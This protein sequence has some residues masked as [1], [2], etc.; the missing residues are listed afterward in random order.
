MSDTVTTASGLKR[1]EAAVDELHVMLIAIT[2]LDPTA[3]AVY[4][5]LQDA[6]KANSSCLLPYRFFSLDLNAICSAKGVVCLYLFISKRHII[7]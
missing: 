6:I 1:A 4:N 3:F 5:T 7:T 2:N